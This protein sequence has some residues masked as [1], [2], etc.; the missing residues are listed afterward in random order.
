[1]LFG[2]I[3]ITIFTLFTGYAQSVILTELGVSPFITILNGF[4]IGIFLPRILT[5]WIYKEEI[6]E[7]KSR[8]DE[9]L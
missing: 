8:S 4:L 2:L 3:S 1:M 7:L 6:E 9:E 5:K